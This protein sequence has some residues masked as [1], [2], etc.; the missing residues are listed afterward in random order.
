MRV[1]IT[2][3]NAD[4]NIAMLPNPEKTPV[5]TSAWLCDIKEVCE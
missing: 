3:A 5:A 1:S 2:W 4:D